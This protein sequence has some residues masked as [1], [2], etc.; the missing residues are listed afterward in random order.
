[1]HGGAHLNFLDG[2]GGNTGRIQ[3][4]VRALVAVSI[5]THEEDV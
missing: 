3:R 5:G 4:P 2:L 1:V